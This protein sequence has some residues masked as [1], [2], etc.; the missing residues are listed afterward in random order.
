MMKVLF[1][2][3]LG[4]MVLGGCGNDEVLNDAGDDGEIVWDD[5]A[6]EYVMEEAVA[7]GEEALKVWVEYE[8]YGDALVE[9]F[10]EVYPDVVV[11]Y[12]V[13]A[14]VDSVERMALDGEAGSGAD[15]FMANHDHLAGAIDHATA[16]PLGNYGGALRER[17]SDAFVE[18]V[19]RD[20]EMYGVPVATESIALFYN[21]TLLEE[22]TGSSK[23]AE[24]WEEIIEL[25]SVYNDSGANQWTIRFMAGELYYAYPV[26]SSLGW[27]L[28]ADGDVES[29]DLGAGELREGLEYYQLLREIWDVNSADATYDSIE[30]EFVKGETPYV[31]TGPWVFSDFDTYS[32][33]N[34]FE[35]GV[36]T[37]PRAKDGETA[38]SLT[39]ISVA[40][41]SGYTEYP[42]AARVFANF[43]ASDAG[44]TALYE[45]TGAIPALTE[46]LVTEVDG[47]AGNE[48][49][50]GVI[51]QS[52]AADLTPQIP[53]YLY[54]AGNELVVN[55][56][57]DVLSVDEAQE[58]A[59]EQY[60]ELKSLAE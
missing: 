32:E 39:G 57:D 40:V 54:T 49:L 58:R 51:A 21:K 33:E 27:S 41:V 31:I 36:T 19:S 37:L 15:V 28:F 17:V 59:S 45:S 12:E 34:G 56:W 55:V 43:M 44:M 16:A 8:S 35:Y 53:E 22:L 3:L 24:T 20:D 47:I 42:A 25:A 10:G 1:L 46:D 14:K 18:V 7:S 60:E 4:L 9:A 23:P 6:L 52:A 13:I 50:A 38:A 26:L 2:S 5:V 11:T 30:N 29:V 48:K